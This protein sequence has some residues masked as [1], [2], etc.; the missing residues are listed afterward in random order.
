MGWLGVWVCGCVGVC[1]RDEV[2]ACMFTLVIPLQSYFL[3]ML[4]KPFVIN[5][6]HQIDRMHVLPIE[7]S[8]K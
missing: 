5:F 6:R 8:N 4:L 7:Y 1:M 3:A 2:S